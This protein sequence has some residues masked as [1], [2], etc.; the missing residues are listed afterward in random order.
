MR[1][2]GPNNAATDFWRNI[3]GTDNFL[4]VCANNGTF[5]GAGVVIGS[6]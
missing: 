1:D 3:V 2:V 5:A 6:L 4:D